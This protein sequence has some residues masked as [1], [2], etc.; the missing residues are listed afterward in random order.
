MTN[1][2]Q[3]TTPGTTRS[4]LASLRSLVP[5]RE[6]IT[7]D[8]ALRIAE[9]QATTLIRLLAAYDGIREDHL[10]GLPRI[11]VAYESLAVSGTSHWN[12][13]EWII[14]IARGDSLARQRFT[15]LHELK[16]VIDHGQTTRLYRGDR[17]RA[18]SQQAELVADYFAG[19]ALVPKRLLKAAWGNRIQRI[20]DLAEH[21]GV[22][23]HAIRVRLAQT[24][25]DTAIDRVPAPR[26]ARPISTPRTE[27]QRFRYASNG[28]QKRRY[29]A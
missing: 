7:F 24:G 6:S 9:L 11:R 14:V 23:E 5:Q 1:T 19:C 21:F 22:S 8:E 4:V 18:A 16:H 26:C 15:M 10:T 17:R 29:A 13:R 28:Y 3:Q 2:A 20:Y 27:T 12:G 25:L